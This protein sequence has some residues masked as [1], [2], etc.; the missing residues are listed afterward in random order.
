MSPAFQGAMFPG[1][2]A[3]P[4]VTNGLSRSDFVMV[5]GSSPTVDLTWETAQV[6]VS[7][8]DQDGAAI[9]GAQW[10]FDGEGAFFAPGTVTAPITDANVYPNET[11]ASAGGWRFAVQAA[12]AGQAVDLTRE[13]TRSVDGSTSAFAFEWRQTHCNMGV[14]DGTGAALRG[15]SWTMLGHTFAEGDAITL[16][17]TDAGLYASLGGALA[18]GIPTVL[19]TNT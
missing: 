9:P 7:V 19:A 11:G 6:A 1:G 12:F 4:S 14:V 13:D 17:V 10:G 3:L 2:F 15:A 18:A 16:P 8:V 5:D